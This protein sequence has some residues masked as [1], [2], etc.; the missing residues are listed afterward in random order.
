[1]KTYQNIQMKYL[2]R[3]TNN[4]SPVKRVFRELHVDEVLMYSRALDYGVVDTRLPRQLLQRGYGRLYQFYI[5]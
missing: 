4:R 5:E 3:E 1:M 2:Y